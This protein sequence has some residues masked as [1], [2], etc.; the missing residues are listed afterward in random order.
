MGIGLEWILEKV[1]GFIPNVADKEK[2]AQAIRDE[3]VKFLMA[4]DSPLYAALRFIEIIGALWDA[5]FNNG[6]AWA[7]TAE[8]LSRSPAG[9]IELLLIVWPFVGGD[10]RQLVVQAVT[11]LLARVKKNGNG[12]V[13]VPT[14]VPAPPERPERPERREERGT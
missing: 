11:M 3:Y 8:N 2:A 9:A 7:A 10:I 14:P 13:P 12:I 4:T 1:L 5:I 6:R